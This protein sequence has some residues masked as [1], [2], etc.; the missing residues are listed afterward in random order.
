MVFLPLRADLLCTLH[1]ETPCILGPP[2]PTVFINDGAPPVIF[3]ILLG[4][5]LVVSAGAVALIGM[6]FFPPFTSTFL[7][8][9]LYVLGFNQKI[10]ILVTA[11]LDTLR[12]AINNSEPSAIPNITNNLVNNVEV[13]QPSLEMSMGS[14]GGGKSIFDCELPNHFQKVRD[15]GLFSILYKNYFS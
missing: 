6:L 3:L 9:L 15:H 10:L 13:V 8:E 5:G 12:E 2:A 14:S 11:M 4:L 1:Y 7:K